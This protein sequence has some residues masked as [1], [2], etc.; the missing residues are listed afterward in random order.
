MYWSVISIVY[1]FETW[2]YFVLGYLPF[3]S[4]FRLAF[5][6]YLVLPQ[7]QGARAIYVTHVVPFIHAHERQ[8]ETAIIKG[9]ESAKASGLLYLQQLIDYVRVQ[10]GLQPLD[11]MHPQQQQVSQTNYGTNTYVQGLLSR[12]YMPNVPGLG[13]LNNT[14]TSANGS[15]DWMGFI[16]STVSALTGK[17]DNDDVDSSAIY[18]PQLA[19]SSLEERLEYIR[20]EEA[21]VRQ[22]TKA[23]SYE[24][25]LLH[26]ARRRKKSRSARLW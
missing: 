8:F 7:T 20:G 22:L 12:F 18:P 21:R 25:S 9:V 4:W 19:S 1:L 6:A 10:L 11:A 5:L 16:G 2:T 17:T 23:L 26:E 24:K 15:G 13:M 3:Y 14:E